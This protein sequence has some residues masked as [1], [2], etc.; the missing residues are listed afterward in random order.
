M[1]DGDDL[2]ALGKD[3]RRQGRLEDAAEYYRRAVD[4]FDA[5]GELMRGI[6]AVRQ[7]AEIEMEA[8]RLEEASLRIAEVL[9]FYRGREVPR[10]E[11]A[12][13]VR[14][15]AMVDE[16]RGFKE[17]ARLL[18]SEVRE[19]YEREGVRDGVVEAQRRLMRLANA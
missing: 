5:Q 10:L 11:M 18:W 15:A 9:L 8:G 6:H 19:L 16:K 1:T 4:A 2:I 12:N 7:L 14:V 3:A 13:A 17:E